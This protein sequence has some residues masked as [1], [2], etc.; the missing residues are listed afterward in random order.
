MRLCYLVKVNKRYMSSLEEFLKKAIN[1][2]S[3]Q[4]DQAIAVVWFYQKY[5]NGTKI[6]LSDIVKELE[7]LKYGKPNIT[8]LREKLPSKFILRDRRNFC[9]I[10]SK[11]LKELDKYYNDLI[12]VVEIDETPSI[13]PGELFDIINRTYIKSMLLQINTSYNIKNFD[14][15]AVMIRRLMESLIIDIYNVNKK[16]EDIKKNGGFMMLDQLLSKFIGDKLVI[17]S[18]NMP[19]YMLKIKELGDRAAHDR[20]YITLQVDIDDNKSIFRTTINELL[21]LAKIIN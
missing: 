1:K 6:L 11:S 8:K 18:R 3:T 14:C 5:K 21:K 16:I 15:V 17:L 10:N 20:H 19:K 7:G 4:V 2:K 9:Y 13:F 12:G